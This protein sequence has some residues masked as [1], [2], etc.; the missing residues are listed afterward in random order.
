MSRKNEI[1]ASE[2]SERNALWAPVRRAQPI[3]QVRKM[4]K[5]KNLL[6]KDMAERMNISEQSLSRLLRGNQN[7]QIDTLYLLADALEESLEVCI[8]CDDSSHTYKFET[9]ITVS[10]FEENSSV[11]INVGKFCHIIDME[12]HRR[13]F[14]TD[15]GNDP[16]M[17]SFGHYAAAMC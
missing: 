6:S 10:K 16:S 14:V 11:G 12:Q 3:Q 2:V 13:K 1:V 9:E 4:M 7:V 17:K 5:K 15:A 8:G